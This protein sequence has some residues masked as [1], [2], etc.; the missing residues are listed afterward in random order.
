MSPSPCLPL[1]AYGGWW[2]GLMPTT[3]TR[4]DLRGPTL[5]RSWAKSVNIMMSH[6][7]GSKYRQCS[8]AV[9][10]VILTHVWVNIILMSIW[11]FT[12][13]RIFYITFYLLGFIFTK[14]WEREREARQ[15]VYM[16]AHWSLW[17]LSYR[18]FW[19]P[20][21]KELNSSPLM[22]QKVLWTLSHRSS[23]LFFSFWSSRF[24]Y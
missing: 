7:K 15:K 17:C 22:E 14:Q 6:C 19:A 20:D 10:G 24:P 13:I 3:P 21:V 16:W 1:S 11:P 2:A 5:Y 23:L 4:Q 18:H 8:R 12:T 9:E